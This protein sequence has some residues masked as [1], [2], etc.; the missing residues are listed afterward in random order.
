MS[1][2]MYLID[3]NIWTAYL[4]VPG[5]TNI[6]SGEITFEDIKNGFQKIIDEK[7]DIVLLLPM[8][9]EAGNHIGH[10]KDLSSCKKLIEITKMSFEAKSPY[11]S[12]KKQLE[13]FNSE[14]L[15][16]ILEFWKDS[17]ILYSG[18]GFGDYMLIMYYYYY[19]L[20]YPTYEVQV[21]TAEESINNYIKSN[22]GHDLIERILKKNEKR[23]KRRKS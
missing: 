11:H 22:M 15:G 19:K 5:K 13:L 7:S 3:T 8:M 14:V 21:W 2:K 6:G 23:R 9:I 18:M 17:N 10:C 12:F 20:E 16:E 1:K 4:K